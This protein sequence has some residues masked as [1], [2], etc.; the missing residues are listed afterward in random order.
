MTLPD[1]SIHHAETIS[2][3]DTNNVIP[4]DEEETQSRSNRNTSNAAVRVSNLDTYNCILL[5][6]YL[7]TVSISDAAVRVGEIP[8]SH[9][10][11]SESTL[12]IKMRLHIRYYNVHHATGSMASANRF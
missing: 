12:H 4:E 5:L 1:G 11:Y 9:V 8:I 3:S 10:V 7:S 2:I 6:D